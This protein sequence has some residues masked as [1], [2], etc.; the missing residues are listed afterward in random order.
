VC[1]CVFVCVCAFVCVCVCS[2]VFVC[3]RVCVCVCY[4][5]SWKYC[6]FS[7]SCSQ[8]LVFVRVC[9][10]LC[11]CVRV[12]VRLCVHVLLPQLLVRTISCESR[13][14]E[15]VN[16]ESRTYETVNCKSRIPELVWVYPQSAASHEL[17]SRSTAIYELMFQSYCTYNQLR[18]LNFFAQHPPSDSNSQSSQQWNFSEVFFIVSVYSKC[19][20]SWHLRI[21]TF[22]Y[23]FSNVVEILKCQLTPYLLQIL[24]IYRVYSS[25]CHLFI[26]I[27]VFGV[28]HWV[29]HSKF[30]VYIG[31]WYPYIY[32]YIEYMR[33]YGVA[34]ISKIDKIIGLLCKRAL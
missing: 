14:Y 5:C 30:E 23:P 8:P 3:V 18:L 17:M 26:R 11:V 31:S 1:V 22:K 28:P 29:P 15:L 24:P 12:F 19:G 7:A 21:F 33:C 32:W 25:N 13:P 2:C 6:S 9:V 16:C 27:I 34:S 4:L 20:A 10:S